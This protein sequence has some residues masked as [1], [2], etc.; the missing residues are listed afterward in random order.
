MF[1]D[2]SSGYKQYVQT[3]PE[4]LER[5]HQLDPEF[6]LIEDPPPT[7]AHV[8][9]VELLRRT[10]RE[11]PEQYE[12]A[13]VFPLQT[14]YEQLTGPGTQLAIYRKKNRNPNAANSVA[15]ELVGLGASIEAS[16]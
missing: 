9:G 3:P 16:R 1:S 11:H 12:L 14:N 15:I 8:P 10:L 2:P 13:K 5:L 6:V 4:V 7:F